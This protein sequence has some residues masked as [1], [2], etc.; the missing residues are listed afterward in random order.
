MAVALVASGPAAVLPAMLAVTLAPA[1]ASASPRESLD[2]SE[3]VSCFRYLL[4]NA[5]VSMYELTLE[6]NAATRNIG[7][8]TSTSRAHRDSRDLG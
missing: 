5:Y 4:D 2:L 3:D 6:P 8:G 7:T 1:S